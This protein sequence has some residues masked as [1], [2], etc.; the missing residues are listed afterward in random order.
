MDTFCQITKQEKK[1]LM[2]RIP[3][4]YIFSI[5]GKKIQAKSDVFNTLREL[6]DIPDLLYENWDALQDRLQRD[7]CI[8]SEEVY[9]FIE[10]AND[11]LLRDE[12]SRQ[13]LL[14]ILSNT[15]IWWASDV[16]KYVVGGKKRIFNVYLVEN[17]EKNNILKKSL[18]QF[19]SSIK[20]IFV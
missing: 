7:Y 12:V 17:T 8:R 16:E 15:V 1:A 5:D 10:N 20:N 11:L 4:K 2:R 18:N 3:I 13:I 6:F 9:L 14:D 19:I